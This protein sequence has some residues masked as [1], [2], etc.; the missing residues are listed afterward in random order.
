VLCSSSFAAFIS[1]WL[2]SNSQRARRLVAL[3]EDD[4]RVTFLLRF[5]RRSD[6]DRDESDF[7]VEANGDRLRTGGLPLLARRVQCRRQLDAELLAHELHGTRRDRAAGDHEI[8]PRV[9]G[10]VH[11]LV[12]GRHEHAGRCVAFHHS[13]VQPSVVDRLVQ[14]FAV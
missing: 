2:V 1:S 10:Q 9:L 11:D 7:A 14:L 5:E 8:T 12:V 3:V 6:V 4:Q 13:L